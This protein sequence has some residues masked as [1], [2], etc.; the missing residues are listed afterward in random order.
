VIEWHPDP[1]PE[2]YYPDP[3]LR[4]LKKT[5]LFARPERLQLPVCGRAG[6]HIS[7]VASP[8]KVVLSLDVG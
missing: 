2:G 1:I 3:P 8:R 5:G 7:P 4:A 6:F